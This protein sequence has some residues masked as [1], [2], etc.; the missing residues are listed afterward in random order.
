MKKIIVL[1]L[2][3][4]MI[5]G[6]GSTKKPDPEHISDTNTTVSLEG[7]S[8]AIAPA[9]DAENQDKSVLI[10][11]SNQN[12]FYS[13]TMFGEKGQLS[14]MDDAQKEDALMLMVKTGTKTREIESNGIK[15]I[16]YDD[17][18][19][20]VGVFICADTMFA[21]T[22]TNNETD[23]ADADKYASDFDAMLKSI[24]CHSL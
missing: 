7:V 1:L 10:T 22:M 14:I 9:W 23:H 6:C 8:V 15:I 20:S 21:L 12:V 16:T 4:L 3:V 17:G 13:L 24:T 19:T 5:A 2:A 11:P 18:N